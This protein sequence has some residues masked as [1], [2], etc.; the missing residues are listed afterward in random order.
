[1][2]NRS[3]RI[4]ASE[5]RAQLIEVGRS[6]FAK[7]GYE[8]GV[9]MGA[10]LPASAAGAPPRFLV[11]ALRDPDGANIDRVQVIKGWVDAEGET[12]ERVYDV[13]WSDGREPDA[14]GNLPPVGNTVDIEAAAARGRVGHRRRGRLEALQRDA[15]TDLDLDRS[16]Q[17]L[18]HQQGRAQHRQLQ[19]RCAV[20]RLGHG[21]RDEGVE[22]PRALQ[23]RGGL[24]RGD[25][26]Q[27]RDRRARR[28]GGRH[29]ADLEMGDEADKHRGE[30]DQRVERRHQFRHRRHRDALR[31]VGTNP[32]ADPDDARRLLAAAVPHQVADLWQ[33]LGK[34]ADDDSSPVALMA[35]AWVDRFGNAQLNV[36]PDDL[37]EFCQEII[38]ALSA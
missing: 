24:R 21:E 15:L 6:V 20:K 28:R 9:P 17:G 32:A 31:N 25:A 3:R 12:Q 7:H 1:M 29:I 26:Q 37:P 11:R 4:P 18:Q 30:A 36:G 5:R 10:D 8:N 2:G 13:A 27:D 34:G 23:D 16:A 38:A 35:K 33:P 14:D 19:G 22:A